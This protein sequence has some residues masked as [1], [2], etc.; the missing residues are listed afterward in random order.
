MS[1]SGETNSA[2]D[3]LAGLE[4]TFQTGRNPEITTNPLLARLNQNS[5]ERAHIAAVGHQLGS[6][7]AKAPHIIGDFIGISNNTS[8]N[9]GDNS[10]DQLGHDINQALENIR[11]GGEDEEFNELDAD[12]E[13][14]G[15]EEDV[16]LNFS[17]DLNLQGESQTGRMTDAI[18][19][20]SISAASAVDPRK[21]IG[22]ATGEGSTVPWDAISG[23]EPS[24]V[25]D[26]DELDENDPALEELGLALAPKSKREKKKLKKSSTNP[27]YPPEVQKL[28]GLANHAYV[29]R[30]YKEAVELYQQVIVNHANVFQAWNI[31]GVIQE[32][33]GNTEKA[34][35]LY[36]VAAHLTPKDGA[37]WKK[38]AVISK[39]CGYDQQAL[40]CFSR[41]YKADKNDMDALW[42]RSIM[43]QI[44]G[45]SPKAIM[46]FQKILKVKQHYMPALEELV[47]I[48]SSL[49]QDNKRYRENMH[50]AMIDYEAAYLHYS[51]LPDKFANPTG[52]PFDVTDEVEGNMQN[53]SFGYSALNMLSELYIMFEEY[54]KPIQMIKIWSRR[55][56]KRSHQT[57]WDDY[58]DDR[59]FDTDMD[60]EE[61]QA[62]LGEN[63]TR[64]LP[65]DLRVKLGICRLMLEEVK[66]AK[67]QFKYL[68]RCSVEDFPDLYEEI[69]ELYVSKQM[70]KEGYNVIR[71]MLQYDEMD[72]PKIWTM[73]GEC[74]RH[75]GQLK[76]AKDFLEQ[77]HRAD[78]SSVDVSMVLAEVYEEMGNL[79]QALTL[80]NY[81]RQV[82]AEKQA[83]AERRRRETRQAKLSKTSSSAAA[84]GSQPPGTLGAAPQPYLEGSPQDGKLR[85]LAPRPGTAPSNVY[86][87]SNSWFNSESEAARSAM[88][89]ITAA[90]RSRAAAENYTNADRDRDIQLLKS[91]REQ[92]RAEK[93]AERENQPLDQQEVI[94]KFN[95]I[96]TIHNR[97]DQKEKSRAWKSKRE[98]VQMTRE[99]RTQYIQVARELIN[100]FKNNRGF[101]CKEKNKPYTGVE[102]RAWRYRRNA[103]D[104][105]S[106]LSEH[107]RDMSERLAKA[108]GIGQSGPVVEVE[109]PSQAAHVPI[110]TTYKDIPFHAWYILMIR[111]AVYLTYEDRYSEAAELLMVMFSANVFY[112]V[113]R[114]RSGIMLVLLSCAMWARDNGAIINAARWLNNFGGLR[115]LPFK[116]FQGIYFPGQRSQNHIFVWAQNITHK[117][118]KRHIARMRRAV[119]KGKQRAMRKVH[120][121]HRKRRVATTR[122]PNRVYPSLP[123]SYN[124]RKRL[125]TEGKS[126]SFEIIPLYPWKKA[127]DTPLAT[128]SNI[129]GTATEESTRDV[130]IHSSPEQS[131]T[132]SPNTEDT[133]IQPHLEES[134]DPRMERLRK[135]PL[136]D[137]GEDNT[138]VEATGGLNQEEGEQYEEINDDDD[139]YDVYDEAYKTEEEEEEEDDDYGETEWE[140]ETSAFSRTKP[141]AFEKVNRHKSLAVNDDD[142][143]DDGDGNDDDG[144]D[145]YDDDNYDDESEDLTRSGGKRNRVPTSVKD[146]LNAG[147][148]NPKKRAI[149]ET[150]GIMPN[151]HR[152]FTKEIYPHFHI[153]MV[154]MLGHILSHSRSHVGS[155]T[156][157][158]ECMDY[159]PNNPMVQFYLAVQFFNL[160][161]Q[162]TTKNRQVA[163]TQGFVFFQ[164]YYRLRCAGY[165]SL[166][167]AER[168]KENEAKGLP[169]AKLP[170]SPVHSVV[171]VHSASASW[172]T[173]AAQLS[174]DA[175][176]ANTPSVSSP[177]SIATSTPAPE[178]ELAVISREPT[179][180]SEAPIQPSSTPT[181]TPETSTSTS[182]NLSNETQ[183]LPPLTQ[184][185]QEAEYNYARGFHQLGQNHLA[186]IHYRRV[187]EM[188]SWREVE[189]KQQALRK[190]SIEKEERSK[191]KLKATGSVE[192]AQSGQSDGSG[193][194][195]EEGREGE[196]PNVVYE[197]D[198][199]RETDGNGTQVEEEE[200]KQGNLASRI[201]LIDDE[202]PTDL[203]REAAFNLAK[204]YMQSGAM[205]EAQLLMR[206]YCTF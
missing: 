30:D 46:G 159:L 43:Y 53:E 11:L 172:K 137:S 200:A 103:A 116:I 138:S 26:D 187:L 70:W 152:F 190:E 9:H 63:R 206:K 57:W 2:H 148:V 121:L 94:Q 106:G 156:Q 22:A 126:D 151:K 44:L 91:I 79:P 134:R 62:S 175:I 145:D 78:P 188:P 131:A 166:A 87:S 113:P 107:A 47:K 88:E 171:G 24:L 90:S 183:D 118:L 39:N 130:T 169:P 82:N 85:Q 127:T 81:V 4:A 110:P 20:E 64:G 71:A 180:Q 161:M 182:T 25:D 3:I 98:A 89:R 99:D 204:I 184:C 29:N 193:E 16:T 41:A 168:E 108:M 139:D 194:K 205:G 192:P 28:L 128:T 157:F 49:D 21:L 153:H 60:D 96:D 202:D 147:P 105:D 176:S 104:A 195:G 203:K 14:E 140:N 51:S 181:P 162:R 13:G 50:Q 141:K 69:A 142:D 67:A 76:E 42:D 80:V 178:L 12:Y 125:R 158:A 35:Q 32:E 7:G 55:L 17:K 1:N 143:Y 73:A 27:V 111:Q 185:Q 146:A 177:S 52:D 97:I 18:S 77:A 68:W 112:S 75:M 164:N 186:T 197:D 150:S 173:Q 84:K 149:G 10:R 102:S 109:E 93:L 124:A 86:I 65:V 72:I 117:Y 155:A 36:L 129:T 199:E 34:L 40:Y 144:Y 179:G 189:R 133:S 58:K 45:E 54:E 136:E 100:V 198:Q 19:A 66:E 15:E 170:I 114:R 123:L 154:M 83:D 120:T 38:L 37:L 122:G 74:L 119:G 196:M 167:F 165:G 174:T 163:L 56:Q 61:L 48:Y 115:S 101:F 92:E 135:R 95:K 191:R 6:E 8:W 132:N 33:L 201:R 23:F 31:M 5:A 59:E 160:S